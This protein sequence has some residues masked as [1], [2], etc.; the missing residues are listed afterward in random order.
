MTVSFLEPQTFGRK[1]LS[2][3]SKQHPKQKT[4]PVKGLIGTTDSRTPLAADEPEAPITV[5]RASR[6]IWGPDDVEHH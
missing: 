1:A 3:T 5:D 2:N 6:F 4:V